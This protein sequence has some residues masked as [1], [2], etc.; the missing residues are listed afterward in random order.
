MGQQRESRPSRAR[1]QDRPGKRSKIARVIE[2]R[3]LHE[4]GD[5]LESYWLGEETTRYSLRDLAEYFNIQVLRHEMETADMQPLDG[6]AENIYRLLTD[7]DVSSG[8]RTRTRSRLTQQGIDVDSLTADFVSHQAVHTYLTKHRN[9]TYPGESAT[10][11]PDDQIDRRMGAIQRL[12]SRLTAVVER[13]LTDLRNT[14]DIT[15]GEFNVLVDVRVHCSDCGTQYSVS[16]L[17]EQGGCSC[18]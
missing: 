11:Q 1:E 14:A 15:L 4:L 17:L 12:M 3:D 6:E 5:Q 9:V 8:V 10:D 13:N 16:S 18:E 2:K 7:D